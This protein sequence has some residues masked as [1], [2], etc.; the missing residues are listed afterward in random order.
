MEYCKLRNSFYEFLYRNLD[1]PNNK[2]LMTFED[3]KDFLENRMRMSHIYQPLLIRNLIDAGGS[4]TLRQLALNFLA[5][6]ESQI[7]HYE[8]TLKNMPVK[9]LSNHSIVKRDGDFVSLLV[10]I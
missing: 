6:D 8:K 3:L 2:S 4:A 5:Y 1:R 10:V 7:I 9:V